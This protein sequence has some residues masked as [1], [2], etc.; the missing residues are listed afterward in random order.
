M[1]KYI[2]VLGFL[3]FFACLDC[4]SQDAH[5]EDNLSIKYEA[6]TR[7]SSFL[8]TIENGKFNFS[9]SDTKKTKVLSKTQISKLTKLVN[10]IDL[11]QMNQMEAPSEKRYTDGAMFAALNITKDNTT[12]SS[13]EFDHGNPPKALRSLYAYIISLNE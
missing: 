3:V 2:K 10:E 11:S 1:N 6:K 12:Y 4:K 5:Q 13:V 9:S 8:M 7:G